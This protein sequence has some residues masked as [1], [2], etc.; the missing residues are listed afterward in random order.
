[1]KLGKLVGIILSIG[2]FFLLNNLDQ[3]FPQ[4][5][6]I[7]RSYDFTKLVFGIDAPKVRSYLNVKLVTIDNNGQL[8]TFLS[9]AVTPIDALV[10]NG[11]HVST[12]NK[13]I[14]TSPSEELSNHAYIVLREYK[15]TI[16]DIT[17][18]IPYE[19]IVS[20]ETL[21]QRL[22]TE[23]V[24]QSGVLGVMTQ[25][26]KKS[27][28]DG[29]LVATE[30][31]SEVVKKFPVNEIIVLEG[32]NDSPSQVPQIGYNCNYWNSYIDTKV[33]ATDEEKQWLKFTMKWESGC[34]AESNKSYYKGLFQWDPCIW[35]EQYPKDNIFDGRAQIA[36]TLDKLRRGGQPKYMWPAVYKKYVSQF[37]ELS[38]L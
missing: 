20:G 3:R 26:V 15:T 9:R 7:R 14:T 13:I 8:E 17:L 10:E 36:N 5:K 33:S 32:P 27:Y 31:L 18:P 21:C 19:R 37:G 25:T 29:N 30:T 23:V 24:K 2:L 11:Y 16:E 6:D 1:M 12:M 38:W 28:E 4:D 22:S 34:N 35:Y